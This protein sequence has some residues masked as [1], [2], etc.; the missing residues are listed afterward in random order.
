MFWALGTPVSH[1]D[2]KSL[3]LIEERIRGLEKVRDELK[4]KNLENELIAAKSELK[5]SR[6][7]I[8]SSKKTLLD[9]ALNQLKAYKSLEALSLTPYD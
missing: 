4:I 5:Q 2:H 3:Q 7:V 6:E 8:N 1:H 9:S